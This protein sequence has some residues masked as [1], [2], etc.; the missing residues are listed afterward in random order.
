MPTVMISVGMIDDYF[1]AMAL[2]NAEAI[3]ARGREITGT[4]LDALDAMVART[5]GLHWVRPEAGT[6]ALLR[7]DGAAPS[8]A[9][10]ER[11]IAETGVMLTPGAIMGM[12][13]HL[14]IGFGNPP[15]VFAEG[16]ARLEEWFA[17]R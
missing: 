8:Y 13:G 6:T 16:L 5:G 17:T 1:A 10:C 15:E 7:Y 2:E 11:L 4:N 9:L 14:R 3:F 12:E